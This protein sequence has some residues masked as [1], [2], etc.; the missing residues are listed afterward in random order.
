M[1]H[2]IDTN[3]IW[4]QSASVRQHHLINNRKAVTTITNEQYWRGEREREIERNP[5]A[6]KGDDAIG[7]FPWT[8]HWQ[9]QRKTTKMVTPISNADRCWCWLYVGAVFAGFVESRTCRA[10]FA[11]FYLYVHRNIINRLGMLKVSQWRIYIH[12]FMR[13]IA[14]YHLKKYEKVNLFIL[15]QAHHIWMACRQ[16]CPAT[17]RSCHL[18]ILRAR[19]K[20]SGHS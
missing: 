19:Q 6:I 8:H 11:D 5:H 12:N 4:F 9:W 18:E 10:H 20:W 15:S 17:S 13:Q 3:K 16:S 14:F 7:F 2:P 1:T